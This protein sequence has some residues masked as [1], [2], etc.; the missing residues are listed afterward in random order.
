MHGGV[1]EGSCGCERLAE[2]WASVQYNLQNHFT[3]TFKSHTA[4]LQGAGP[5]LSHPNFPQNFPSYSR[6]TRWSQEKSPSQRHVLGKINSDKDGGT[7]WST[8]PWGQSLKQ[9]AR[10]PPRVEESCPSPLPQHRPPCLPN[11]RHCLWA[12]G[13]YCFQDVLGS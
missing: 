10:E 8:L 5:S 4:I 7:G 11:L 13:R 2:Y 3:Q 1:W 9:E 6:A 12:T